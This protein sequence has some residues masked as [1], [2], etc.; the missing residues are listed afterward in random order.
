M[1]LIVRI[2]CNALVVLNISCLAWLT[3]DIKFF[4]AE[5]ELLDQMHSISLL[6]SGSNSLVQGIDRLE[7]DSD[8]MWITSEYTVSQ[9]RIFQLR[10]RQFAEQTGVPLY[11]ID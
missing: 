9:V 1:N 6:E 5:Q 4:N 3:A 10:H 11:R 2:V 7:A 8:G